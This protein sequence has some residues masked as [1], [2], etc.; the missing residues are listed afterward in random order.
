[1]S[2]YPIYKKP[3]KLEP[4]TGDDLLQD[5]KNLMTPKFKKLLNIKEEL[6]EA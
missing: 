5:V 1:M 6:I 3:S 4:K 2:G